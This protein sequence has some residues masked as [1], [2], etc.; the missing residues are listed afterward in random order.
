VIANLPRIR[1][2]VRS[3]SRT[4]SRANN[5]NSARAGFRL[6]HYA[7]A[8]SESVV[9]LAEAEWKPARHAAARVEGD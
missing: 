1:H 4:G 7:V 5:E 6:T 3:T 8:E 2:L 9:L